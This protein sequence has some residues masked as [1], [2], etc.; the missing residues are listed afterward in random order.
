MHGPDVLPD[1]FE[2]FQDC[3]LVSDV[4]A[5]GIELAGGVGEA[6]GELLEAVDAAG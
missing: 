4:A 3:F 1:P 2:G 6:V 5:K